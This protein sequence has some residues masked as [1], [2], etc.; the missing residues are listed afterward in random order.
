M[1][2]IMEQL[3]IYGWTLDDENLALASLLTGDPLLL[4]GTHGS[5][6]TQ[7]AYKVAQAI[8]R[9]FLAYDASK[10][11]FEDVLGF[12]N[13]ESLKAGRVEYVPSAVTI[14]DKEFVLIDEINR[15]LPELQAKWLEIIRS[16]K[17]M[18]FP[19]AVKWV[20][21]AM[22]PMHSAYNGTQVMDAALV[23][24][25]AIFL[26]PPEALDMEE[27]DRIKVV[28]HIN[29]DD[30]PSLSQWIE[31]AQTRTVTDQETHSSGQTIIGLLSLAAR[32]FLGLQ[33]HFAT[34]GELLSRFSILLLKETDGK[35]KLDGRRLGFIYRNLLAVRAVE[36]AR[37]DLF[38]ETLPEFPAS[39]KKVVLASIPV[40][41]N[42]D[43]IN[44]E[45]FLHK[46]EICLDLLAD[47]FRDGADL[48]RVEII[49][50]LFTCRD[51]IEKARIL[52][53]ENLSD[54]AKTKA[55]NDLAD[56][57]EDVS[58]LAYVA[59]QVE[60][61]RPGT[62]PNELMEKVSGRVM[63]GSLGTD[64]IPPL[65]SEAI[66]LTEAVEA[67]FDQPSDLAKMIAYQRLRQLAEKGKVDQTGIETVKR[68]IAADAEELGELLEVPQAA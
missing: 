33:R 25:F 11:L 16:R 15:A 54:L 18:G 4:I 9:N 48:R 2:R 21:A 66:E 60:A 10:A 36:L 49:Y 30:A 35:I 31:R 57:E 39:A 3:G 52:L 13:V 47:Y 51:P 24:R 26:Y 42:E 27:T 44:K 1:N 63:L 8:G 55:W 53:K 58:I 62:I 22:N 46:V 23:G 19:T 50:R 20:W 29:G 41:I 40:G 6:K 38:A 61:H 59:L 45:E 56:G 17:I 67:L 28:E 43:G 34:L 64:S 65:K 7:A 68:Q 5:A 14:W 37:Q 12:P 32:H